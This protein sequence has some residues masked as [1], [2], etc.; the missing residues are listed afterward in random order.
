MI[1]DCGQH[2]NRTKHHCSCSSK[3]QMREDATVPSHL[4][5]CCGMIMRCQL[6]ILRLQCVHDQGATSMPRQAPTPSIRDVRLV[7]HRQLKGHQPCT[8]FTRCT[9]TLLI[10]ANFEAVRTSQMML[11][12]VG[13]R[14][15][16]NQAYNSVQV[17]RL[18][19]SESVWLCVA[20]V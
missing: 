7:M 11:S 19:Y 6:S 9:S 1:L 15:S 12:C 5:S 3:K 2:L 18:S 16:L 13:H 8:L 17:Q 10:S 20:G 14:G 4:M